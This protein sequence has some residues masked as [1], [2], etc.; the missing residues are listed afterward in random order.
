MKMESDETLSEGTINQ[1][2]KIYIAP[3]QDTYSEA[4]PTQG[5]RKEQSLE[6]GV[7]HEDRRGL[8]NKASLTSAIFQWTLQTLFI[9]T[10]TSLNR[11]PC[12]DSSK[13]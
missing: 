3:I 9:E 4:L 6:G 11:Y 10:P 2:I 1:S 12:F 8:W 7:M 13:L 5:K